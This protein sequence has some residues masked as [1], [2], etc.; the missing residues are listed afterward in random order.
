MKQ[1]A[2]SSIFTLVLAVSV[3]C[4]GSQQSAS[5]VSEQ[6]LLQ[7]VSFDHDCPEDQIEV[8]SRDK[9]GEKEQFALRA[10]GNLVKYEQEGDEFKQLEADFSPGGGPFEGGGD[11]EGAPL[12]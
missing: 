5:A 9:V 12:Q 6:R 10:C 3:G 7:K 11:P 4:A 1:A 2:M 8:E